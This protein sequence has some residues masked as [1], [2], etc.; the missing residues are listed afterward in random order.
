MAEEKYRGGLNMPEDK[1]TSR[2]VLELIGILTVV[3]LISLGGYKVHKWMKR[4][5]DGPG[6]TGGTNELVEIQE[7]EVAEIES[8]E[9]MIRIRILTCP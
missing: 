4:P 7:E 2:A 3:A 8:R 9:V 6:P 1:V 5:P